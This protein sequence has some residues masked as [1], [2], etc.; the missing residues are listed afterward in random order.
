MSDNIRVHSIVG[1]FLEHSRCYYFENGGSPEIFIGSADWMHRN[2]DAR[3]EAIVPI[4]NKTLQQNLVEILN[5]YLSDNQQSWELDSSGIYSK[6][7]QKEG[8]PT[9]SSQQ[10]LMERA[11]T[12]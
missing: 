1:R 10:I 2:L 6:V 11:K 5:L 3:V 7:E 12:N 9:V 4:R 8:G